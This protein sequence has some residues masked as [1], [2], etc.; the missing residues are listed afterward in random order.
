MRFTVVETDVDGVGDCFQLI[1][2]KDEFGEWYSLSE[3]DLTHLSNFLNKMDKQINCANDFIEILM[4]QIDLRDG[5][6]DKLHKEMND[7]CK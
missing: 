7:E 6:L 4:N 3:H 1:D 2:E 5:E